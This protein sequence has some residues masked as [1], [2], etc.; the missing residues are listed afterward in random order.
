MKSDANDLDPR[1]LLPEG[2]SEI[3]SSASEQ[4]TRSRAHNDC[5]RHFAPARCG[6][7]AVKDK[8]MVDTMTTICIEGSCP[9]GHRPG[10]RSADMHMWRPYEGLSRTLP[11]PG[12]CFRTEAGPGA[13]A[14]LWRAF[15][16]ADEVVREVA[17][18]EKS[19]SCKLVQ[20]PQHAGGASSRLSS[21][22]CFGRRTVTRRR[23]PQKCWDYRERIP[24][25]EAAHMGCSKK[26]LMA[27][28]D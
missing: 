6:F 14:Y 11:R 3:K 10:K 19:L 17:K 13:R 7:A 22:A 1:P 28:T 4:S 23:Q 18:S 20:P 12:N 5:H 25:Q 16:S 26:R 9:P 15:D 24:V 21:P 27:C 2:I 8:V